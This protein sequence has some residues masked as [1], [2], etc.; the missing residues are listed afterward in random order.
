MATRFRFFYPDE[1]AAQKLSAGQAQSVSRL[2]LIIKA[3]PDK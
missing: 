3:K 1:I 2:F